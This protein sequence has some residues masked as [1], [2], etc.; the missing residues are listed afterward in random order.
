[1]EEKEVIVEDTKSLLIEVISESTDIDEL[2][3]GRCPPGSTIC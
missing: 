3:F 1:M 2:V